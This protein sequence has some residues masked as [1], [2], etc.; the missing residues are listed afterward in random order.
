V[1]KLL[2]DENIAADLVAW[3]RG[4]GHDVLYAAEVLAQELDT[5]LLRTAE[6]EDRL[7]LTEDK[8]FGELVFRDRLNSHGVILLRVSNLSLAERI[9]RLAEAWSVVESNHRGRFIVITANK[10]RVR[11]LAH[12]PPPPKPA[13]PP[14]ATS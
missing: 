14:P 1:L 12:D 4:Q 8:D 7:V 2:A 10:V 13:E 3:L 11:P 9:A 6:A 5:V